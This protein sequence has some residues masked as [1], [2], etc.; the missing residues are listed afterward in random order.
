M[1]AKSGQ[2]KGARAQSRAPKG[3]PLG[4][5]AKM[6]LLA[7]RLNSMEMTAQGGCAGTSCAER[8]AAA[9]R[10]LKCRMRSP[11]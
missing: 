9:N 7:H 4:A 3:T 2:Q 11:W 5:N 10:F 8:G 1:A 6:T